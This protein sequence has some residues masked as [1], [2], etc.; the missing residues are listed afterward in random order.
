MKTQRTITTLTGIAM[1]L[2]TLGAVA[3][4]EPPYQYNP[5]YDWVEFAFHG[6]P[7]IS[8]D[9]GANMYASTGPVHYEPVKDVAG[10][11]SYDWF[12]DQ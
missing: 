6:N 12:R 9:Q 5:S 4:H 7:V 8:S 10:Q 3:G 2:I 11:A 1:G